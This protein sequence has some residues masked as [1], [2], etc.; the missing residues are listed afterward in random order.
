MSANQTPPLYR[1]ILVAACEIASRSQS[2]NVRA[3]APSDEMSRE[4]KLSLVLPA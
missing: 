2:R 3:I 1:L 4:R